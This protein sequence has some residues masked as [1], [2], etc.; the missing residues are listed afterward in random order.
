MDAFISQSIT[1]LI[2]NNLA[3]EFNL[4]D[5]GCNTLLPN[6]SNMTIGD[7]IFENST[8]RAT[9]LIDSEFFSVI[10]RIALSFVGIGLAAFV[11]AYLQIS[12]IQMAAERQVYKIRLKYYRAVLRQDIAWFDENPTGEIS[13]RLS[14]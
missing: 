14:E 1:T 10:D 7:F 8:M 4:T 3:V 6:V 12:F 9:C 13:T 5:I 2:F 11:V